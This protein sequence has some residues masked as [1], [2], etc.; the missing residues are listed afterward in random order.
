MMQETENEAFVRPLLKRGTALSVETRQVIVGFAIVL[1]VTIIGMLLALQGWKSRPPGF[2]MLTYF[3]S[4]EHL[5]KTGTPARYGDVSSYGS[6]SPPGTTWLLAPGIALFDDPRLSKYVGAGFLHLV[7]LIGILLLARQCFGARTAYLAVLLYGLSSLGLFFAG[8]LWPIGHPSFYVWMAYFAILWVIR[9]DGKYLAA[10]IATWTVGMYVDM[11]ITPAVLILPTLWLIYRPPLFSKLHL[12]AAA[13]T[14]ALWYPYLQFET[15]RGL[16]DLKSLFL[17]H[18]IVPANSKEAWCDPNLTLQYLTSPSM[19][20]PSGSN[21]LQ[22]AQSKGLTVLDRLLSR[23]RRVVVNFNEVAPG[24]GLLLTVLAL[25]SLGVLSVTALV[26][27]VCRFVTR[28]RMIPGSMTAKSSLSHAVI[29]LQEIGNKIETELFVLSLVVPWL[30]LLIVAELDNQGRFF[31]LWPLQAIALSAF[32]TNIIARLRMPSSLLWL[33]YIVLTGALVIPPFHS[34]EYTTDAQT[35]VKLGLRNGWAGSDPEEVRVVD[36][37]SNQIRSDG[38][39]HAA[40]GY[41]VFI[42]EFMANY[43]IIDRQY[44]VGAEFDLLFKYRHGIVNTN[45]CAEG[46]SSADDYRILQTAPKRG[47]QEPRHYFQTPRN[48]SFR[49]VQDFGLYQVFKRIEL[50]NRSAM[51]GFVATAPMRQ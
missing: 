51:A 35:R 13:V 1:L 44:K 17:R 9:R 38:R 21:T 43:N 24:V 2:D 19:S 23:G 14:L 4:A 47:E 8:S 15:E 12:I 30:T 27:R 20:S 7:G 36:Y 26:S 33:S 45:E 22:E 41:Q 10:G 48:T 5:L 28:Q 49:L 6:F 31:W 37:V 3:N 42:Y 50:D 18:N 32:I 29:A 39:D 46:L 34:H 16:A 25:S 40:I 11:A